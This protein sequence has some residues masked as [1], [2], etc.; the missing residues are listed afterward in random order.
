MDNSK[1]RLEKRDHCLIRK[2]LDLEN[3][4]SDLIDKATRLAKS[5]RKN[6]K[7]QGDQ[8]AKLEKIAGFTKPEA[9]KILMDNAEKMWPIIWCI[10]SRNWR[11]ALPMNWKKRRKKSCPVVIEPLPLPAMPAETN[12]STVSLPVRRNERPDSSA[13]RQE[14]QDHRTMTGVEII[15]TIRPSDQPCRPFSP[16]RRQVAKKTIEKLIF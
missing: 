2:L 12:S 16:I 15:L 11:T 5:R 10:A 6:F 3:Q 8:L 7:N 1:I 13:R 9:E 14:Y 4:K